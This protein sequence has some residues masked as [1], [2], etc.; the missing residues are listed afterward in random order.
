MFG[1][2]SIHI[3]RNN[4]LENEIIHE[5]PCN[6]HFYVYNSSNRQGDTQ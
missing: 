4:Y 3:L 2:C 6:D 5:I 1:N